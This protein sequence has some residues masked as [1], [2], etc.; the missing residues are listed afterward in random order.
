M[1]RRPIEATLTRQC[2]GQFGQ[3]TGT[4]HHQPIIT[5]FSCHHHI[6]YEFHFRPTV[7]YVWNKYSVMSLT[8][9]LSGYRPQR[10]GRVIKILL[11]IVVAQHCIF[12]SN[13]VD[14][15]LTFILRICILTNMCDILLDV[16]FNVHELFA[17][18]KLHLQN[19]FLNL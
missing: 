7:I 5:G 9:R 16:R 19:S 3:P 14:S 11:K 15:S 18:C 12:N 17:D 4:N 10:Y 13:H 8:V 1:G 2:C 6:V